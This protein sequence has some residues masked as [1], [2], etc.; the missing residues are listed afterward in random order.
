M[1]CSPR[2]VR[3]AP[4]RRDDLRWSWS[5]LLPETPRAPR[6][7]GSQELRSFVTKALPRSSSLRPSTRSAR[8]SRPSAPRSRWRSWW[9][10]RSCS[11]STL[12]ALRTWPRARTRCQ[13]S[14]RRPRR[15]RS[16]HPRTCS[17]PHLLR[18]PRP[19][20]WSST[21]QRRLRQVVENHRER[22][23]PASPPLVRLGRWRSRLLR[24][25]PRRK[26]R[27]RPLRWPRKLRRPLPPRRPA[28]S[29]TERSFNE[30]RPR[31]VRARGRRSGAGSAFSRS[32]W[33]RWTHRRPRA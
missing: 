17:S 4:R 14:W 7:R 22:V 1:R 20:R 33:C 19:R 26:S 9:V 32:R 8:A 24:H 27:P 13:A 5:F 15:P 16:R 11:R 25:L 31:L 12:H 30:K 6:K 10:C 23:R 29:R 18:V 2:S 28:T 21:R 3:T